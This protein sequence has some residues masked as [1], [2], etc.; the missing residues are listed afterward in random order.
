VIPDRRTKSL[1]NLIGRQPIH[2]NNAVHIAVV[3]RIYA[4]HF[5]GDA[6]VVPAFGRGGMFHGERDEAGIERA[7]LHTDGDE[8]GRSADPLNLD[9]NAP[10]WGVEDV[11]AVMAQ[12]M[13]QMRRAA[14]AVAAKVGCSVGVPHSDCR[15]G[16]LEIY[17]EEAIRTDASRQ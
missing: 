17:G 13:Q 7:S 9:R 1:E 15:R 4:Y 3:D 2:K 16:R 6:D 12:K 14:Q 8:R 5:V 10:Y 11:E